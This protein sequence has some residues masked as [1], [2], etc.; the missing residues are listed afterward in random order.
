M[1]NRS[2]TYYMCTTFTIHQALL[3]LVL[4][5]FQINESLHCNLHRIIRLIPMQILKFLP[6]QIP[7]AAQKALVFETND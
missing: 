2:D 5:F 3:L 4:W 6:A 1:Y 7:Y